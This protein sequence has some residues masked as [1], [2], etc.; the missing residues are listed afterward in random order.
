MLDSG[1]T[2]PCGPA[3]CIPICHIA[4]AMLATSGLAKPIA[5]EGLDTIDGGFAANKSYRGTVGIDDEVRRMHH[6]TQSDPVQWI[7]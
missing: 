3:N 1:N 4:R 2:W 7:G 5:I 6:K